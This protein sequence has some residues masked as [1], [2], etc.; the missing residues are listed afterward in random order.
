MIIQLNL[1]GYS[2]KEKM[3]IIDGVIIIG[4]MRILNDFVVLMN[5]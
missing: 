3:F 5:I 2:K 4:V 1:L